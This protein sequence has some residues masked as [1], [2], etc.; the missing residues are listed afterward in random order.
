MRIFARLK[1][2]NFHQSDAGAIA[3]LMLAACLVLMLFAWAIF[4]SGEAARQKI[5]VQSAADASAFSQVAVKA[6]A[7]N[8]MAYSN[9][10]K[11]SVF[12]I[13]ATYISHFIAY[14]DWAALIYLTGQ[15]I[16]KFSSKGTGLGTLISSAGNTWLQVWAGESETDFKAFSNVDLA[17]SLGVVAPGGE[18]EFDTSELLT[19]LGLGV[20]K[21]IIENYDISGAVT[22]VKDT[23]LEQFVGAGATGQ[24][25][26]YSLRYH[27]QDIKALDN[28]QRYLAGVTP[29]WAWSEQLMRGLRNGATATGSFPIPYTFEGGLPNRLND[30]ASALGS[31]QALSTTNIRDTLPVRPGDGE[32]FH[33]AGPDASKGQAPMAG[34]IREQLQGA[35]LLGALKRAYQSITSDSSPSFDNFSDSVFFVEHLMNLLISAL[36]TDYPELDLSMA[37]GDAAGAIGSK[38][39]ISSLADATLTVGVAT[40]LSEAVLPVA[41]AHS[42][43]TTLMS[44]GLDF[45]QRLFDRELGVATASPWVLLRYPSE[46]D[47]LLNTSNIVFAYQSRQELFEEEREKFN[48]PQKDYALSDP[49]TGMSAGPLGSVGA[50]IYRTAG[51]WGMAR[52]EIFYNDAGE[53][54]L[55][56]PVWNARLRPIAFHGELER[57]HYTLAAAYHDVVTSMLMMGMLDFSAFDP[58]QVLGDFVQMERNMRAMGPSTQKGVVK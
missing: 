30:I 2:K 45:T 52:A 38:L 58:L 9:V 3:I 41:V 56:S 14:V 42:T 37:V 4:D 17:Q 20:L 33:G 29:W 5:K 34:V 22:M 8:M 12:A 23:D 15:A 44:R 26:G 24:W 48:I 31:S 57:A 54:G 49:S 46:A 27:A 19:G 53:P 13:H 21:S 10:A 6:R 40:A 28:Y 16:T 25:Q 50:T 11:R 36:E 18:V 32:I 1:I 39:D 43:H 35:D 47:W 7:M 51:N 55:W